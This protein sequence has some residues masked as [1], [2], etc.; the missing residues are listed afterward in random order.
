ME[1]E[2]HLA[3]WDE[4]S[5]QPE[6]AKHTRR[7]QETKAQTGS[8]QQGESATGAR[9]EGTTRGG[10]HIRIKGVGDERTLRPRL[11]ER[12]AENP[13]YREAGRPDRREQIK[14]GS[15]SVFSRPL[16]KRAPQRG[17]RQRPLTPFF[18]GSKPEC[19]PRLR[20]SALLPSGRRS[21]NARSPPR[22][23]CRVGRQS[24]WCEHAPFRHPRSW[25]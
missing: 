25:P 14:L 4:R 7:A 6:R 2:P 5:V 20:P 22:H 12:Q 13:E 15:A 17:L 16:P 19:P 9:G 1:H 3:I 21:A 11:K 24:T 10:F 8:R 23:L 18:P